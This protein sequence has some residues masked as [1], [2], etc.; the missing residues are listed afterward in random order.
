MRMNEFL[1]RIKWTT[2]QSIHT[3][4]WVMG[5]ENRPKTHSYMILTKN[6]N[7]YLKRVIE[8]ETLYFHSIT[9]AYVLVHV[10]NIFSWTYSYFNSISDSSVPAFLSLLLSE[11][12]SLN[13]NL[14][15]M[16]FCLNSSMIYYH[17]YD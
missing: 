9:C 14:V 2:V 3:G 11:G 10:F 7:E 16:L 4:M 17:L 1:N 15:M 5:L 8:Y 13:T 12:C 6:N